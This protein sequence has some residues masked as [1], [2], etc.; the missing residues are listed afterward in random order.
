MNKY[1]GPNWRESPDYGKKFVYIGFL[2]LAAATPAMASAK[3]FLSSWP[4]DYKG[5][6]LKDLP[7]TKNLKDATSFSMVLGIGS[8]LR[9]FITYWL[10]C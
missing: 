3:N 10:F 5:T 9:N 1:W 6:P 8:P 7:I 4:S 2:D